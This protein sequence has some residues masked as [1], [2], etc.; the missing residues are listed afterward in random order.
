MRWRAC[1][2]YGACGACGV[3]GSEG[4]YVEVKE[5]AHLE[6]LGIDGRIILK[7]ILKK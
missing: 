1:G 3:C 4:K 2:A 7:W 5:R 6:D